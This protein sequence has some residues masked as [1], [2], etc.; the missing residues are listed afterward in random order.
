MG[1]TGEVD[2]RPCDDLSVT[3]KDAQLYWAIQAGLLTPL[4]FAR[5]RLSPLATFTSGAYFL[6]NGRR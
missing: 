5:H 1:L 3:T 6:R 2:V 4:T